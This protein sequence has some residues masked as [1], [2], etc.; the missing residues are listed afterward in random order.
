VAVIDFGAKENILRELKS[1]CSEVSVWP[2]RTPAEKIR[3]WDPDGIMLTNGPGDPTQVEIAVDTIKNLLGWRP[4]FGICMGHQLLSLAL[5]AQTFKIKFGHRGG[6]HPVKDIRSNKVY[7]TSQNHGY[8]VQSDSLPE[9][10]EVTHIN[11]NDQT[12]EGIRH[13]DKKCFS[14]QFHP[15]SHPGPNDALALFD[16]F[17]GMLQ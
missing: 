7:V 13:L 17:L 5:G 1:R 8:A 3:A 9:G 15:E 10:V 14:V 6:N 2:A 16:E 11:L 12:V 4:I